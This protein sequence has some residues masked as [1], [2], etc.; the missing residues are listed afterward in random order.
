MIEKLST[1]KIKNY[2]KGIIECDKWYIGKIDK[3]QEKAICIYSNKR[4]LPKITNFKYLQS[5]S[6]IPLTM[7][8]RWTKNYNLAEVE[9]NKIFELIDC[10]SFFIDN[11]KCNIN[12]L[13]EGPIDLGSDETGVYEFSIEFNLLYRK[14]DKNV[15]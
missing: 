10:S 3:N 2:L 13:Y 15:S 4:N 9:A 1:S 7:L 12:C 14:D 5:Y 8:I 11:F 6:I